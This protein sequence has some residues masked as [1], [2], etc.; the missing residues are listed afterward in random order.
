MFTFFRTVIN[1]L[2]NFYPKLQSS[3]TK[4][5]TELMF[6]IVQVRGVGVWLVKDVMCAI[7]GCGTGVSVV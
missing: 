5:E 3:I 2:Q 4:D 6:S 7:V 1:L